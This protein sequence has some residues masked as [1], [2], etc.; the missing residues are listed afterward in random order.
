MEDELEDKLIYQTFISHSKLLTKF[1]MGFS[2]NSTYLN[3]SWRMFRVYI[4]KPEILIFSIVVLLVIAYL[5]NV[6]IR[7]Q[8]FFKRIGFS[9]GDT[10]T[11]KNMQLQSRTD[12]SNWEYK[13]GN[14]AVFA[15]QGRRPHMEDRFVIN[16]NIKNTGVSL[17]AVFDGHGGD[18]SSH[19]ILIFQRRV[20]KYLSLIFSSPP[21]T[22]P[23]I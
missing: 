22:Q 20:T 18:V 15:V 14:V 3:Y 9:I 4:L 12:N 6:D 21:N 17:F 2:I 1:I 11:F 19:I 5:Q 10:T 16:E 13:A 8:S 7:S 23:R